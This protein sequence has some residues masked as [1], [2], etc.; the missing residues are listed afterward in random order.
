MF[1]DHR[2]TWDGRRYESGGRRD[3]YDAANK[4]LAQEIWQK[5]QYHYPG[6]PWKVFTNIKQGIALI[7]LPLFTSKQF[8]INL[9]DLIGDP[10]MHVVMKG[11]G[12]FLERYEM[13]RSG[14]DI[15]H[16]LTAQAKFKPWFN[17][18]KLAD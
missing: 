18:N 5:L 17:M 13:P 15:S 12:E 4:R 10:G 14:F 2:H 1:H 9:K 6:H 11:A 7:E 3:Q 16:Y 8:I